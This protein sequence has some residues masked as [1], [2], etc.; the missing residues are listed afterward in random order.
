MIETTILLIG[1]GKI[2]EKIL[3][4][5]HNNEEKSSSMSET[6]TSQKTI[7]RKPIKKL[8]VYE[9]VIGVIKKISR[10]PNDKIEE[11][12]CILDNNSSNSLT[13]TVKGYLDW[14][15]RKVLRK[16]G[17]NKDLKEFLE[18]VL[19]AKI[20]LENLKKQEEMVKNLQ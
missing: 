4:E 5:S 3:E 2:L 16:I 13:E 14:D 12:I 18:L 10:M 20:K 17:N 8:S 19:E 11:I 6:S 15:E 9:E 1:A 7:S